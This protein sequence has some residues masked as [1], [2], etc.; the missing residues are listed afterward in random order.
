MTCC[1]NHTRGGRSKMNV[2]LLL[3]VNVF[4]YGL[5]DNSHEYLMKTTSIY[6]NKY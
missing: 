5:A 1:Q 6:Q 4:P 2:S 3:E